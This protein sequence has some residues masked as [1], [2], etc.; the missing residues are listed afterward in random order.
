[1][2]LWKVQRHLTRFKNAW[3]ATS[4]RILGWDIFNNFNCGSFSFNKQCS[5]VDI[6][7]WRG[8]QEWDEIIDGKGEFASSREALSN[9]R[10]QI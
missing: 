4:Q 9:N 3:R 10:Q 6:V 8:V 1:V 2:N 7:D 5:G